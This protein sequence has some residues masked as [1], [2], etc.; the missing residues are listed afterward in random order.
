M[1]LKE[2]EVMYSNG[3]LHKEQVDYMINRIREA[4][5]VIARIAIIAAAAGFRYLPQSQEVVTIGELASNHI[6]KYEEA[7]V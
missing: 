5:N 2:I 4:D 7:N 3:E 1:D 6:E